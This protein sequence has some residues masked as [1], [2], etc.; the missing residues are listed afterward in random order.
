MHSNQSKNHN[1]K[2]P[3]VSPLIYDVRSVGYIIYTLIAGESPWQSRSRKRLLEAMK[4][5]IVSF[6]SPLWNRVSPDAFK[7][8]QNLIKVQDKTETYDHLLKDPYLRVNQGQVPQR[9]LP[10]DNILKVK[11]LYLL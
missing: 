8:V 11:K 3:N 4:S 9:D 10:I 7:F 5:G 6:T 1:S 2:V